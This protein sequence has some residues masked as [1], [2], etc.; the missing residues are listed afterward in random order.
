[1][2]LTFLDERLKLRLIPLLLIQA[3]GE[4]LVHTVIDMLII[5]AVV[6]IALGHVIDE[7]QG[8]EQDVFLSFI[9]L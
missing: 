9:E 2:H 3:A 5:A 1:M 4:A 7:L 6:P 8:I